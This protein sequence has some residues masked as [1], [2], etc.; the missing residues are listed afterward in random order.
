MSYTDKPHT[1]CNGACLNWTNATNYDYAYDYTDED[2]YDWTVQ[3]CE[4]RRLQHNTKLQTRNKVLPLLDIEI[5]DYIIARAKQ[6]KQIP[7]YRDN[8]QTSDTVLDRRH[9]PSLLDIKIPDHI[10]EMF[11]GSLHTRN[12]TQDKRHPPNT[13]TFL[14]KQRNTQP[15]WHKRPDTI[16]NTKNTDSIQF[17]DHTKTQLRQTLS[18]LEPE[19]R[20]AIERQ[21]ASTARQI[22]PVTDEHIQDDPTTTHAQ[23]TTNKHTT[24]PTDTQLL[25]SNPDF[26]PLVKLLNRLTRLHN[27]YNN[28]QT[29]PPKT[30]AKSL[31]HFSDSIRPPVDEKKFREDID[32]LTKLYANDIVTTVKQ[33][34][35]YHIKETTKKAHTHCQTDIDHIWSTVRRQ[36]GRSNN[37]ITASTIDEAKDYY[38]HTDDTMDCHDTSYHS[39]QM[40]EDEHTTDTN[41]HNTVIVTTDLTTNPMPQ[42]TKR[43]TLDTTNDSTRNTPKIQRTEDEDIENDSTTVSYLS[44]TYM[45]PHHE[46]I[47]CLQAQSILPSEHI[48]TP[49]P[50]VICSITDSD[51]STHTPVQH[52]ILPTAPNTVAMNDIITPS[53]STIP[54]DMC[55]ETITPHAPSS[56]P[57]NNEPNT[58]IDTQPTH[59]SVTNIE[60]ASPRYFTYHQKTLWTIDRPLDGR[61]ILVITDSNGKTWTNT[62]QNWTVYAFSGAHIDDITELLDKQPLDKNWHIVIIS[63]GINDVFTHPPD[64][65]LNNKLQA[66]ANKCKQ[67]HDHVIFV[68][69]PHNKS[70]HAS[71]HVKIFT[72]LQE[73]ATKHFTADNCINTENITFKYQN[74]NDNKHYTLDTAD[75][76][77]N[78]IKSHNIYL[79]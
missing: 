44:D 12:H 66:L 40:D 18:E 62:P 21:Q 30:L 76:I 29:M 20:A 67:Q 17:S 14:Q 59:T 41:P 19:F 45:S 50:T 6:N 9:I 47:D 63:V 22:P 43:K 69:P 28:W 37:R 8:D 3:R 46:D 68:T 31:K 70:Y 11:E 33:H 25:S 77:I 1:R 79:N 56:L 36:L 53:T 78:L 13:H 52:N 73:F 42:R 54:T 65:D 61:N 7:T 26:K 74:I 38:E 35:D 23:T 39:Q 75:K 60:H 16:S 24:Y 4:R 71:I 55:H 48:S 32:R 57:S 51:G 5:P 64:V 27:C 34:I 2:D 15:F 72:L 58:T 10:I 49:K